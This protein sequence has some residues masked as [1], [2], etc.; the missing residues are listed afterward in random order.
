MKTDPV[1]TKKQFIL[2]NILA[3]IFAIL[4]TLIDK[5]DETTVRLNEVLDKELLVWE[6]VTVPLAFI[7]LITLYIA[8]NGLL[9][10]KPWARKIYVYCYIPSIFITVL[11]PSVG[12]MYMSAISWAFNDASLFIFALIW[13]ICIMPSLYQPLFSK[14]HQDS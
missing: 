13:G 12:W 9:F 8:L 4:S 3:W 1:I 2:L 10:F 14:Q 5:Y 6:Y 11:I 7:F